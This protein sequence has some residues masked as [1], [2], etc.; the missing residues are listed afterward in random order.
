MDLA[1]FIKSESREPKDDMPFQI[2]FAKIDL[3]EREV[4]IE[5]FPEE[6]LTKYLGGRGMNMYL[7]AKRFHSQIDPLGPENPLI[8]GT[9]FLTGCLNLESR[10]NISAISSE[11]G[12]LGDT[13]MGGDFGAELRYTGLSLLVIVGKS[14]DPVYLWIKNGDVQI[15][16][17]CHLWGLGTVEK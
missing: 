12:Y 14:K 6:I 1:I 11:T 4:S 8:F 5:D 7:L 17:A 3:T 16:D 13:N 2:R 9:G 10:M 15:R